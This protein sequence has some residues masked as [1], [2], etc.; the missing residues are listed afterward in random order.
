MLLNLETKYI[1]KAFSNLTFIGEVWIFMENEYVYLN[2]P[3]MVNLLS[4]DEQV[5]N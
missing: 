2:L 3:Y 5:F 4:K 1:K